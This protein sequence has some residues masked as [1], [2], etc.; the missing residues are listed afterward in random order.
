MGSPILVAVSDIIFRSKIRAAAEALGRPAV[1]ADGV[2][3]ALDE[4]RRVAPSL[5][6]IDLDERR[7]DALELVRALKADPATARAVVIGYFPHVLA[8]L[9]ERAIEAGCDRVLPRSAFSR[10]L[11]ELLAPP[12]GDR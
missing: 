4:A 8:E 9:R 6:V 5:V 11:H 3:T 10:Q 1:A 2:A 7:F 12:D